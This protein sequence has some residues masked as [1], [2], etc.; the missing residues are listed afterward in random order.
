MHLVV[1]TE[2]KLPANPPVRLLIEKDFTLVD[3][4]IEIIAFKDITGNA[5]NYRVVADS[6][7]NLL[8]LLLFIRSANSIGN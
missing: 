6:E 2:G 4:L 1:V 3:Q 5:Q 8:D 7:Q